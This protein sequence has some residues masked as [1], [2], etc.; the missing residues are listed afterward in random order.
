MM[1]F[2]MMVCIALL[3]A[4][5][6]IAINPDEVLKDPA[7]ETRARALSV[8]IRCLVCQNQSIDDSDADLA[9]DLRTLVRERLTAGDSDEDIKKFLVA[10]Y[11]KFILLRPPVQGETYL[12]WFGPLLILLLGGIGTFIFVRRQRYKPLLP[13]DTGLTADEE[14][15]ITALL[16]GDPQP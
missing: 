2:L 10:R 3:F 16:K 11:G 4:N 14:K 12:L 9:K 1:R 13:S 8:D 6:A 15:R 5:V 7:L